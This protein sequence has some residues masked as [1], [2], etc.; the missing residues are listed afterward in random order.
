MKT[1]TISLK[2]F[3][4]GR[5][6]VLPEKVESKRI[7]FWV[8]KILKKEALVAIEISFLK[9]NRNLSLVKGYEI[10]EAIKYRKVQK[11]LVQIKMIK[12]DNSLT[13]RGFKQEDYSKITFNNQD[14]VLRKMGYLGKE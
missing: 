7:H 5:I 3:T 12:I 9:G 2:Y 11:V 4:N 10:L 13:K 1:K 6:K 14:S 8:C